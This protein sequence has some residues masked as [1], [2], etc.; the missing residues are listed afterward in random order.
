MPGQ[1]RFLRPGG[2]DVARI[3]AEPLVAQ[4]TPQMLADVALRV[5]LRAGDRVFT[6]A[7]PDALTPR[8]T[9][10]TPVR[11]P[12]GRALTTGF[13]IG[14]A[15]ESPRPARP[16]SAVD[17]RVPALPPDLVDLALWMAEHYVCSVGEALWAMIPPLGALTRRRRRGE[18][19]EPVGPSSGAPVIAVGQ[20]RLSGDDRAGEMAALLA[21]RPAA[22]VALVADEERFAGY[23]DAL[24]WLAAGSGGAIFLVP[25]VVQAEALVDWLRRHTHLPVALL[26]GGLTDAQ[27]W[28]V[29]RDALAGRVRVVAGT[30][31]AVFAPVAHLALMVID[32]EEDTAY[33][34]ERS[35]RYH[36]RAVAEE[37]AARSGAA[38]IWGTP[39][40]SMEVARAVQEGRASSIVRPPLHR[41]PVAVV[42]VRAEAGPLGGLFGRRLYQALRRT[43]PRERAILFVPRR[44]YADFLLCHECGWVPRC[45]RCGL[46]FTYHVRQVQLRCHLCGQIADVPAV[47]ATCGGIHL[48]PHGVGTERVERAAR[49]LF[50]GTPIFR[51][52]ADAAPEEETQQQLWRQFGRRGGLLIGTHLLV[53]GVGQLPVA[54]VGA[55]GVDA[56]LNLPDFRA[57]ERMYQVLGRLRALA[58]RE[59]IIQTFTPS[60]PAL[61]ALARGDAERFYRDELAARQRFH[62]PPYVSLLNIIVTGPD[63]TAVQDVADQLARQMPEAGEVLGPS[64]APLARVRGRHRW[65]VLVKEVEPLRARR[66]LAEMLR[67]LSLPRGMKVLVDADPVDLL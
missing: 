9:P 1:S 28:A 20:E 21:D 54:V 62:Y 15:A 35:P 19:A 51:L 32:H 66:A 5:P 65:Q 61:R 24:R 37:R 36:A 4:G 50:R 47:C 58:Q 38:L 14:P 59:V 44:G 33:K 64:P 7:V 53:K 60:H 25:E 63:A 17:E 48:R 42:D 13:V 2:A 18:P 46:A 43:L 22:R 12:F 56:G 10:G 55:V 30:R 45:P 16:I 26:H 39:V 3:A 52:D 31:L 40:P 34:E 57:S 49:M 67:A 27:R 11:V 8:I 23:R 29:W 6:F 41:P